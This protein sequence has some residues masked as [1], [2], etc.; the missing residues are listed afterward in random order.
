MCWT[1]PTLKDGQYSLPKVMSHRKVFA[2]NLVELLAER[3]PLHIQT[4]ETRT[5]PAMSRCM[6]MILPLNI[7]STYLTAPFQ[8]KSGHS[9]RAMSRPCVR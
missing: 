7:S 3:V 6:H 9:Y 5:L 8:G 4:A 1:M 2:V